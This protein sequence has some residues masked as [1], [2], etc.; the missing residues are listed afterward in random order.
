MSV[1]MTHPL[2]PQMPPSMPRLLV[3]VRQLG[4]DQP[5]SETG[6]VDGVPAVRV[7]LQGAAKFRDVEAMCLIS[8]GLPERLAIRSAL[9][10][11]LVLALAPEA[12]R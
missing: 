1:Q 8:P 2:V 4:Y 5:K 9:A 7:V 11:A 3:R 10:E 6:D 12:R